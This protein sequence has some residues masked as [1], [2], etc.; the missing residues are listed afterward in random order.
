[1]VIGWVFFALPEPAMSLEYLRKMFG[2]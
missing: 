1:V 2:I